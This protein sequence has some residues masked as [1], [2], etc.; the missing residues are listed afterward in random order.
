[1]RP[2]AGLHAKHFRT[3]N[4]RG[5]IAEKADRVDT[6]RKYFGRIDVEAHS[7]GVDPLGRARLGV[8]PSVAAVATTSRSTGFCNRAMGVRGR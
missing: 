6:A 8:R 3:L 5:R 7:P 4:H 2:E 1:M